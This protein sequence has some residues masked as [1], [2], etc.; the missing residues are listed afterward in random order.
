MDDIHQQVDLTNKVI[1]QIIVYYAREQFS[2]IITNCDYF[3]PEPGQ[4]NPGR[5]M[6]V[7]QITL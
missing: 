4:S 6:E 5:K 3:F 2:S 1:L 7:R